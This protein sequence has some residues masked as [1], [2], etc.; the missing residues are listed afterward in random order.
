MKKPLIK[1]IEDMQTLLKKQIG[2][3]NE[4][5]FP[6]EFIVLL[7]LES[8]GGKCP[9]CGQDWKKIVAKNEYASFH[10]YDPACGCYGRCKPIVDGTKVRGCGNSLHREKAMG[11]EG[12]TSCSREASKAIKMKA[13]D[14]VKQY[15]AGYKILK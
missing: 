15:M 10:Y 14:Q 12:C 13:E 9:R 1:K 2:I 3:A 11:I 8:D 6:A 4:M 7:H 5:N